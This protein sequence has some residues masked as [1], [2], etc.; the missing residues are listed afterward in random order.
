MSLMTEKITQH[1]AGGCL[2]GALR[3]EDTGE[4]LC[5]GHCNCAD[6]HETSGFKRQAWD[7]YPSWNLRTPLCK[8]NCRPK[9]SLNKVPIQGREASLRNGGILGFQIIKLS[10]YFLATQTGERF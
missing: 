8:F 5:A 9:T 10:N 6:C 2:C 3:Y 4:P 7:L 1:Y